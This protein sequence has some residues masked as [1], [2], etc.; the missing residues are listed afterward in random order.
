MDMY[1]RSS[2]SVRAPVGDTDLF[3]VEVCLHQGSALSPF[4]F[5]VVLDELSESIQEP[6]PWCMMFADDIVLVAE[7][8]Q[9]LNMRLEEW[10][11]AL[12]RKVLRISRSKTEYLHCDFGGGESNT[13]GAY[14]YLIF[15]PLRL[16]TFK[17]IAYIPPFSDP[18]YSFAIG[19]IAT[20]YD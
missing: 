6:L 9:D 18:T 10:R 2:T 3:P 8:K 1:A 14:L 17:V 15:G 7:R 20:V 5:D 13:L 11:T 19:V 16:L 12:E 4:L